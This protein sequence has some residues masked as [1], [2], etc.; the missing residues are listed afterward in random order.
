MT[1][2]NVIPPEELC[3]QHLMAEYR[4]MPRLVDFYYTCVNRDIPRHYVLGAGHMKFFL[5]KFKF[6]YKRHKLIV[7]E[8]IRRQYDIQYDSS[9]F[10]N[11]PDSAFN[12][13]QPDDKAIQL[14]R[15]RI[16]LR[17]PKNPRW[18]KVNG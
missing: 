9:I 18:S 4:E 6:L 2:I 5:D 13:W 10:L 15:E 1:R 16:K 3:N 7:A 12:D 14:N 11:V 8:L 17:M